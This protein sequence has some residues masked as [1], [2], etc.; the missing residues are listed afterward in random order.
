MVSISNV[1]SNWHSQTEDEC[2]SHHEAK[3]EKTRDMETVFSASVTVKFNHCDG[4]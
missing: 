3:V 4:S 2:A 1:G